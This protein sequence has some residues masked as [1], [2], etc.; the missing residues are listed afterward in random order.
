MKAI[1]WFLLRSRHF[2]SLFDKHEEH[3]INTKST[4]RK[5]KRDNALI[6]KKLR[7]H[8]RKFASLHKKIAKMNE[9]EPIKIYKKK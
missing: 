5:V 8:E 1:D 3:Q 4:F 7:Q 2:R 6:V 9:M